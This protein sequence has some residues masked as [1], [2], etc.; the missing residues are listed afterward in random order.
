MLGPD[1]TLP[2]QRAPAP[3]ALALPNVPGTS[4]FCSSPPGSSPSR[5][6]LPELRPG[7]RRLGTQAAPLAPSPLHLPRR[8]RRDWAARGLQ[9]GTR[10]PPPPHARSQ[11]LSG[12]QLWSSLA[13]QAPSFIL[14]LIV[15]LIGL[16]HLLRRPQRRFLVP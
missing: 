1:G 10:G 7:S 15:P 9:R 16:S 6:Q 12:D 8:P 13:P 2:R 4:G 11:C 5:P 14:E 3:A